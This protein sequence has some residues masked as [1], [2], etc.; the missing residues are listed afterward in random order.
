MPNCASHPVRSTFLA[1]KKLYSRLHAD[2]EISWDEL[3][4]VHGF[5]AMNFTSTAMKEAKKT[6]LKMKQRKRKGDLN[7]REGGAKTPRNHDE[8]EPGPVKAP[9]AAATAKTKTCAKGKHPAPAKTPVSA[10]AAKT[11]KRG[12]KINKAAETGSED[13]DNSDGT[14]GLQ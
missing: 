13:S 11:V 2:T 5:N 10:T 9:S 12:K 1:Y 14:P 6:A 4:A 8:D 3:V 7:Q